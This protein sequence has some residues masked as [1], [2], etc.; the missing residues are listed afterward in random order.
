[1]DSSLKLSA[2]NL[3]DSLNNN[4]DKIVI[5]ENWNKF[6]SLIN[7][8]KSFDCIPYFYEVPIAMY[9]YV[10]RFTSKVA[11]DNAIRAVNTFGILI[12]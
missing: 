3:L 5:F 10:M 9:Q 4:E 12:K 7:S 8:Y 11:D 2:Q 6:S 1:M